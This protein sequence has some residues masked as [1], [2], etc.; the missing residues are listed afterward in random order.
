MILWVYRDGSG[1]YKSIGRLSKKKSKRERQE[2]MEL[3]DR[4]KPVERLSY[5][6]IFCEMWRL[7]GTFI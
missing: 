3:P 5:G 2:A 4:C 7:S 6:V 1:V